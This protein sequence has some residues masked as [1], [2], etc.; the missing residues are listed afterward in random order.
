MAR[1]IQGGEE[2]IDFTDGQQVENLATKR[3]KGGEGQ[4]MRPPPMIRRSEMFLPGGSP[5]HVDSEGV[6]WDGV[7]SVS[8]HI[9][10]DPYPAGRRGAW[11]IGLAAKSGWRGWDVYEQTD[12]RVDSGVGDEERCNGAADSQEE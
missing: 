1:E 8:R 10:K 9:P 3:L 7:N 5:A 2:E 4:A 12:A 11:G 6:F